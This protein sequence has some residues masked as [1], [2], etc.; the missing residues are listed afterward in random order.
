MALLVRILRQQQPVFEQPEG[1]RLQ[2]RLGWLLDVSG[3]SPS[4]RPNRSAQPQSLFL[5]PARQ[6]SLDS[7]FRRNQTPAG[8]KWKV[9]DC[10]LD[11]TLQSIP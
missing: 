6:G 1:G 10:A 11:E 7:Y 3:L 9:Y 4:F 2:N 5:S 8:R